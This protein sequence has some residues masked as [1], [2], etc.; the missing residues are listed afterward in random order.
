MQTILLITLSLLPIAILLFYFEKQDRGRKEPLKVKWLVFRWGIYA[1]LIAGVIELNIDPFMS[2]LSGHPWLYIFLESFIA[3]AL[4]EESMKLWVVMRKVYRDRYF[5]EVMDGISYAIIASLGF[6]ALENILYVTGSGIV[7]GVVRALLSVP[8]HALFSGVMGYYIGVAHFAKTPWDSRRLLWVGFGWAFLYH[9]LFDFFLFAG[10]F[11]IFMVIPLLA[12]MGMHLKNLI[13]RAH[14]SDHISK[15]NP[16]PLTLKKIIRTTFAVLLVIFAVLSIIGA[17]VL[18]QDP[19]MDYTNKDVL[20][21]GIFALLLF[22]LA[23]KLLFKK[24][25]D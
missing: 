18:N 8:A 1:A 25:L 2:R 4:I 23:F 13:G 5:D 9:G 14:F 12:I 21:V 16:H 19:A 17:A 20:Y 3:T 24:P 22:F 10:S 6:A 15:K 7:V 11:W